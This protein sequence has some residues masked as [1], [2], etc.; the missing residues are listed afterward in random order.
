VRTVHRWIAFGA[1]GVAAALLI[2]VGLASPAFAQTT[3]SG[4]VYAQYS[5]NTSSDTLPADSTLGGHLN[6]FNVTRAYVNVNGKFDHGIVTRVTA[7]IFNSGVSGGAYAFRLKY[8]YVNWTPQNS[9]LTYRLGLLHT[10][11]IDWQE[12]LWDYRMEGPTAVDRNKFMTSS[13][14]G[15][16]VEGAF[17]NQAVN[18]LAG[19]Y[20][21]EGYGGVPGDAHKDLMG[22][23][24]V[25]VMGT[26]DN[27]R[28]GGL[29]VTAYGQYGAPNSG[30]QRE[31]FLGELSYRSHALTLAA[32]YLM[33]KDSVH[34]GNTTVGGGNVT[35]SAGKT[36]SLISVFGVLHLSNSPVSIVGRV[37]L[38]DPNTASTATGDKT[39]TIIAGVS[40]DVSHNFRIMADVDQ[41]S[42]E[43][44][45]AVSPST[46]ANRG[47]VNL[48]A[49]F[50]Y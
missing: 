38:V 21:G 35:A 24:T 29:R 14:F 16:A 32:D 25:R 45:N 30:G 37:D 18:F 17:N 22:R 8:A 43:S 47:T 39:T 26:N 23:V 19:I 36:A 7:D 42:F 40:Y 10:P 9:N 44:G 5:Y 48:H 27:S 1:R 13:D 6:N 15:A 34:G 4:V 31:R 12:A 49:Q 33:A 3:I 20:D 28:V 50:T 2:G 11:F 41:T 46:Y